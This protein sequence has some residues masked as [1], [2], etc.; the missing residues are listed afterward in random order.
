MS[1]CVASTVRESM[2]PKPIKVEGL[3]VVNALTASHAKPL[4]ILTDSFNDG[5]RRTALLALQTEI[6]QVVRR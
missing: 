3:N 6:K 5:D 1:R 4:E 2:K